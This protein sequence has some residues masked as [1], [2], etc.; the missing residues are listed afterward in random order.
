MKMVLFMSM[1]YNFLFFFLGC[2]FVISLFHYYN[3]LISEELF[4]LFVFTRICC[5]EQSFTVYLN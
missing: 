2:T 3:D 4:V 1:F 5:L